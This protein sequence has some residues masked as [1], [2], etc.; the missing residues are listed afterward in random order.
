MYLVLVVDYVR[1]YGPSGRMWV[2][3]CCRLFTNLWSIYDYIPV[4]VDDNLLL[5]PLTECVLYTTIYEINLQPYMKARFGY[6]DIMIVTQNSNTL[7]LKRIRRM[8]EKILL[9]LH[10]T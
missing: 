6:V 8:R 4:H 1:V 2:I 7:K 3:L 10:K 9:C 5:P